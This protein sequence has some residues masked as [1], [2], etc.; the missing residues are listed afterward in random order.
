MFEMEAKKTDAALPASGP[1]ETAFK[2]QKP[3]CPNGCGN[4]EVDAITDNKSPQLRTVR[5]LFDHMD[6]KVRPQFYFCKRCL[7]LF[8]IKITRD[9][10]GE[11]EIP[12]AA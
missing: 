1:V 5:N 2:N 6:E 8:A 10:T 12:L 7:S 11:G 9:E 3:P 4:E